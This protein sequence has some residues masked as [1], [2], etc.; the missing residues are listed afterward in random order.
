[1]KNVSLDRV[2]VSA[3]AIPMIALLF[4]G[5]LSYVNMTKFIQENAFAERTNLIIHKVE[6]LASTLS[7]AETGQRDFKITGKL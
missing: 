1:M 3:I 7:D 6:R 4:V 2:T 5:Y